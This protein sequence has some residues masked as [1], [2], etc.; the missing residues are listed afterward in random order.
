MSIEAEARRQL[1]IL[2]ARCVD[3]LVAEELA[4]KLVRSLESRTPLRV[5]LGLDPTAPDLHIDSP[6][7][8]DLQAPDFQDFR[9]GADDH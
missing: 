8:R 1:E 2:T 3:V 4:R 5:K 6:E 9:S 7:C